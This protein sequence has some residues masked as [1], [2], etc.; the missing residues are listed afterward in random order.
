MALL[1]DQSYQLRA[2]GVSVLFWKDQKWNESRAAIHV[3]V[4]VA[5]LQVTSLEVM[6][7]TRMR[8]EQ[9]RRNFLDMLLQ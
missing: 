5:R 3:N 2:Q 7:R 8:A 9:H 4:T 6:A 1:Y